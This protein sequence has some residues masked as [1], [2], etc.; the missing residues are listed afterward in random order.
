M[1][2]LKFGQMM[3]WVDK[4]ELIEGGRSCQ[5]LSERVTMDHGLQR[6]RNKR[7]HRHTPWHS[8][9]FLSQPF[10]LCYMWEFSVRWET[11]LIQTT[12][13]SESQE[14]FYVNF[15]KQHRWYDSFKSLFLVLEVFAIP[16]VT[17]RNTKCSDDAA[18]DLRLSRT[19]RKC[20]KV[21]LLHLVWDNETLA[22]RH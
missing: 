7:S 22:K 16:F 18:L 11:T 20:W 17:F 8:S 10:S 14:R 21:T 3:L 9:Q 1:H 5:L 2:L 13:S 12:V 19:R 6:S 15:W 4:W